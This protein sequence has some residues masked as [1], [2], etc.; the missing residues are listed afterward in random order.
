MFA[1]STIAGKASMTIH[2]IGDVGR[3]TG[4]DL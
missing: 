3:H 1:A 2:R 4:V